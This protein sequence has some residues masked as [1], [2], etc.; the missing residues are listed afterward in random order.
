MA[1]ALQSRVDVLRAWL[2]DHGLDGIILTAEA[3]VSWLF[4]GR[5]HVN[6]AT[7]SANVQVLVT[8]HRVEAV[9]NNIEASRLRQEEGLQCDATYVYPWHDESQREA[10]LGRWRAAGRVTVDTDHALALRSL[11]ARMQ[12]DEQALLREAGQRV[13]RAVEAACRRIRPEDT[14]YMAAAEM[15]AACYSLGV[16]PI[17]VLA[18]GERRAALWRHPLPTQETLGRYAV[19][20]V[21]GR[22][23]GLV[24]SAT[25]MVAFAPPDDDL[26]HRH[27]AVTRVDAVMMDLSRPGVRLRD[28]FEAA[29]QAYAEQGF[30]NEWEHHHQGG[31]VGYE[32]REL[33]ADPSADL[34]LETGHALA[35]NPTI[36]GVKSEDTILIT[37][38]GVEVVTE[39]GE[40]PLRDVSVNGRIYRRPALWVRQF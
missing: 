32:S 31:L 36:R 19:L 24:L 6:L 13:G 28:V 4:K 25:R 35:W 17:V 14:E 29:R 30:P 21:C 15:A 9:C 23:H 11:R 7:S 1:V 5:F 18:A 26:W 27:V 37:A 22:R 8:A 2:A 39:T 12:A 16:E 38:D 10:I 3:N 33:R 34:V 40:F 20:S